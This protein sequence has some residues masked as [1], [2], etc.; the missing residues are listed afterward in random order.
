VTFT[1]GQTNVPIDVPI[2]DDDV[3]EDDKIFQLTIILKSLPN[4]VTRG[5]PGTATVIIV[6]DDSELLHEL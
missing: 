2:N 5:S 4:D 1:A 3:F 6:D